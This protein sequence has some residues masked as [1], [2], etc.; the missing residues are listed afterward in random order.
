MRQVD[1]AAHMTPGPVGPS[2]L[3]PDQTEWRSRMEEVGRG[4]PMAGEMPATK[5]YQDRRGTCWVSDLEPGLGAWLDGGD[6]GG[7]VG[8]ARQYHTGGGRY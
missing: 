5:V 6:W 4:E 3:T 2:F 8:F 7:P 1:T